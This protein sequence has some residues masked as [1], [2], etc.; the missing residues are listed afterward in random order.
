MTF[1][2]LHIMAQ[3]MQLIPNHATRTTV[4]NE[5]RSFIGGN[6]NLSTSCTAAASEK[7]SIAM[8]QAHEE[9][10]FAYLPEN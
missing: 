7:P 4:S 6:K 1:L 3:D 5:Y 10:H 2:S 9:L 8:A